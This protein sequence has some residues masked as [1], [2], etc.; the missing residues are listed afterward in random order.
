[1]VDEVAFRQELAIG[2]AG[3]AAQE[4]LIDRV[5]NHFESSRNRISS[6]FSTSLLVKLETAKIRAALFSARWVR[7]KCSE[8]L[9]PDWSRARYM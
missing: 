7:K 8:R 1:M 4:A 5:V 3:V 9:N 6:S 2:V